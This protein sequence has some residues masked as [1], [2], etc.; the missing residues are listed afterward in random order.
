MENEPISHYD[1]KNNV[2]KLKFC[3]ICNVQRIP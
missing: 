1:T 3:T 2:L